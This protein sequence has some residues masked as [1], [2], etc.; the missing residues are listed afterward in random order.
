MGWLSNRLYYINFTIEL[1]I[2]HQITRYLFYCL[3]LIFHHPLKNIAIYC[4]MYIYLTDNN[5]YWSDYRLSLNSPY[6]SHVFKFLQFVKIRKL[7]HFV[8]YILYPSSDCWVKSN[9]LSNLSPW[10][11]TNK[12]KFK[13]IIQIKNELFPLKL[14]TTFWFILIESSQF[15]IKI[16]KSWN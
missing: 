1:P 12:G 5:I 13:L 10:L 8:Y 14:S 4:K 9:C 16:F 6:S 2:S 11:R 3:V 7:S 15:A